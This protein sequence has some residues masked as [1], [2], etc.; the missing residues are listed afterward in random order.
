MDHP[1][2]LGKENNFQISSYP[3]HFPPDCRPLGFCCMNYFMSAIYDKYG[4]WGWKGLYERSWVSPNKP[5]T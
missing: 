2:G 3:E 4:K 1:G 5:A